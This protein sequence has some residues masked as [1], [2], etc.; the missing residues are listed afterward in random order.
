VKAGRKDRRRRAAS[1]KIAALDSVVAMHHDGRPE[2][3]ATAD[4]TF[5]CDVGEVAP[6][7]FRRTLEKVLETDTGRW[8][9]RDGGSS[10]CEAD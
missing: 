10:G 7:S 5:T 6:L 4:F 8:R 1:A 3:G 9:R 2:I